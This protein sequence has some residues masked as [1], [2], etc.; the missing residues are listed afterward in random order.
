[1]RS[2]LPLLDP[3]YLGISHAELFIWALC[4]SQSLGIVLVHDLEF[5]EFRGLTGD[6]TAFGATPAFADFLDPDLGVLFC[7]LA[8]FGN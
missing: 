3:N 6:F 5:D 4:I 7:Y 2:W 1:M 8:A